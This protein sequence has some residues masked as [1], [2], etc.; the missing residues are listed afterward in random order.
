M[1]NYLEYL[2]DNNLGVIPL[3][4]VHIPVLGPVLTKEVLPWWLPIQKLKL[5]ISILNMTIMRG[6][7]QFMEP[8]ISCSQMQRLTM[9]TTQVS[10]R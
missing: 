10:W 4:M 2:G 5:E 3:Q 9:V 1:L 8:S 6:T 7:P